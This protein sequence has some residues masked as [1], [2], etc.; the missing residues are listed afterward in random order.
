M[1]H[2]VV[3]PCQCEV[4][5]GKHQYAGWFDRQVS[6]MHRSGKFRCAFTKAALAQLR[7]N[8]ESLTVVTVCH[9]TQ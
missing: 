7:R 6:K 5:H 2:C 4:A 9:M 1:A 8:W 3:M